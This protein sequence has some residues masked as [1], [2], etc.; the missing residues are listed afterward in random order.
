MRPDPLT[1]KQE[2]VLIL[3]QPAAVNKLMGVNPRIKPSPILGTLQHRWLATE[4]LATLGCTPG[5]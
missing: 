1:R 3:L 4:C 5:P 2:L